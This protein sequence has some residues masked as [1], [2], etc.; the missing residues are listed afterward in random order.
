MNIKDLKFVVCGPGQCFKVPAGYSS[1]HVYIKNKSSN[2]YHFS[3]VYQAMPLT[4]AY[5]FSSAFYEG[6]DIDDIILAWAEY[7]HT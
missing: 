5:P 7:Q 1:F 3:H 4:D 2:E 6:N